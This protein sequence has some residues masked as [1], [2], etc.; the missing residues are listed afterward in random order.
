MILP[1]FLEREDVRDAFVSLIAESIDALP[2]GARMGTSSL[3]RAAQMLRYRPDLTIVPFRG[4]VDT[5]LEKLSRGVADATLLAAAGLN[6]LGKADRVTAFLDPRLF[7]PAPAQGAIGIE[8]R[9][10]D[11]RMHDIVTAIGHLPTMLTVGAE[12]AFLAKLD[13]SCRTPIGAFS[14]LSGD[15][16]TLH[17]EILSPDGR[18]RFAGELSGPAAD[19]IRI[20]TEL[21]ARLLAEAGPEFL[22]LFA[23]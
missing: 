14:D 5:R 10:G 23:A 3:R 17:G 7:P 22:D 21:G 9:D 15:A 13:G 16:L 18:Q 8:I 1:V 20:G 19:G 12:R 4:N 2:Q 6:R 11:T